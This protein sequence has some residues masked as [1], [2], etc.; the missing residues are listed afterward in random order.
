MRAFGGA[1]YFEW[2]EQVSLVPFL[3]G[4]LLVFGGWPVF[5]WAAAPL[6]FLVYMVPLPYRVE[7]LFDDL[8]E[9]EFGTLPDVQPNRRYVPVARSVISN[10][11]TRLGQT[12]RPA[13]IQLKEAFFHIQAHRLR[14]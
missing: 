1:V 6:L 5:R 7:I 4:L 10:E 3:A 14:S 2:L 13:T 9:A 12:V 11:E 8:A